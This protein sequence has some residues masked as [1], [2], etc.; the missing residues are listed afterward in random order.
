MSIIPV[1]GAVTRRTKRFVAVFSDIDGSFTAGKVITPGGAPTEINCA[2]LEPSG[3]VEIVEVFIRE[4]ADTGSPVK[5]DLRIEWF[6]NTYALPAQLA[7][8]AI[9]TDGSYH[10][11]LVIAAAS[12]KDRVGTD[13]K[14]WAAVRAV[15]SS[16]LVVPAADGGRSIW[17]ALVAGGTGAPAANAKYEV[18]VVYNQDVW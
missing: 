8:F 13:G 12:W 1:I 5:M 9:P 16:R 6:S 17:F 2:A 3:L 15:P 18:E 4:K 14:N 7:D 11:D 10:G